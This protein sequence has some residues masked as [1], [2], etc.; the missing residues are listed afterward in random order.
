MFIQKPIVID[1]FAGAGGFGLGFKM[2]GYSVP[3]ALEIDA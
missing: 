3:L 1:L 2:A